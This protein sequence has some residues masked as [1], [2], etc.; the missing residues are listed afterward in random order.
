[1][2]R[3]FQRMKAFMLVVC[4]VVSLLGGISVKPK[5]VYAA[6]DYPA[7]YKNF[8]KDARIDEWNFYNRE[9]TSFVAWCLNSRNGVAFHNHYGGVQWGHAKDWGDAARRCGIAVDMNPAK[10]SVWWSSSGKYGHVA[11]VSSVDGNNVHIEEYNYGNNGNYHE[12][13]VAANSA[14]GYIHIKDIPV[15][16]NPRGNLDNAEGRTNTVHVRGWAFDLDAPGQS[17]E[18]HVY[19][20]GP[21]G[22]GEGHNGIVAN[23]Y[24]EDVN[25]VYGTGVY[26]GFDATIQTSLSGIQT[27]YVYALNVGGG[28]DN[29]LIGTKT[30]NITKDTTAPKISDVQVVDIDATGY[31]VTCCV[32]DAEGIA[33]VQ[34]PTWT[35]ADDQDDLAENW[36]NNPNCRGTQDGTKWSFRVNDKD[37][38]YERGYYATHIY[39]YDNNGNMACHCMAVIWLQNTYSSVNTVSYNGHTYNLYNDIL[40]W[41]EAKTK[42]EELGGHL[43]TITSADEQKIVAKLI[44]GQTRK[45]YWIGGNSNNNGTW[46]NGEAFSFSNWEPGEPNS[47]GGG[48]DSYGIYT[49]TGTWNDWL[50]SNKSLGLGFICEWDGKKAEE[51]DNTDTPSNSDNSFNINTPDDPVNTET[52]TNPVNTETPNNP[53]NTETP[54]NPVN[55]ETPDNPVN[56]ETP[57][58]PVNTET[59]DNPVNT[60]T[61]DNPVNTE[62][63]DNPVNTETPDN[64][65]NTEIPDD[66]GNSDDIDQT[67]TPDNPD[68]ES[69]I[70]HFRY[71]LNDDKTTITITKYTAFD[72]NIVIPSIIDGYAVTGIDEEAFQNLTT[73]KTISFPSS[74]KSIGSYAFVG[75]TSLKTVTLPDSLTELGAYVF[76]GCTALQSA[77]LN[78][79][80]KSVSEG[81]FQDCTSL[82]SVILPDTVQYIRSNAFS[83][84][85]SL[86]TLSLPKSL[87]IVYA[88]AFLN[89]GINTIQYAGTNTNW[90]DII[91]GATG[92]T[93]FLNATVT[94]KY[95]KTFSA[96]KSK[97]NMTQP[98]KIPTV[99]KVK[100]F[101]AKAEKKKLELTWEK[102][103]GAAGYQIQISTKRNFK[104][105]NKISISKSKKTYTKKGLKSKKKYYIRI[106]AYMTYKDADNKTKKVYGKWTTIS[107]K[108]E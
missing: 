4:M 81:L 40:T 44:Q 8:A 84:C 50:G 93:A 66:P 55:T 78:A 2:K 85:T 68:Q 83:G 58:N 64:P 94:G 108:T 6:D 57:D 22:V 67:E 46:V 38:N 97:W 3:K 18:I 11:W 71:K 105:A 95:G 17:L 14:S 52:P 43:V 53:V 90:E 88:N 72:E 99:S 74:L 56:T 51:P 39:A 104:G 73:I 9:C 69:P 36:Q 91:I 24:R 37:H 102:L 65:V 75:C 77:E 1:M 30:V 31:T 12:R 25:N 49:E 86:R 92:N 26:H 16:N 34:F 41:D 23:T 82:S 106:R 42:C 70:T 80:C 33:K 87:L 7:N 54:D 100:S 15:G 5:K 89:S 20:G 103:S 13:V 45:G 107:K 48:E 79:G 28:T 60:E 61:P 29:P 98:V 101:R 96:N 59:P 47:F 21:A 63:P 27:V 62:T 19:I 10:G 35:V 76:Q 32:E